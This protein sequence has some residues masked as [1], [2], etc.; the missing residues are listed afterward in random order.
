MWPQT[1]GW[2]GEGEGEGVGVEGGSGD[3]GGGGGGGEQ[4]CRQRLEAEVHLVWRILQWEKNL[5]SKKVTA[6]FCVLLHC[7]LE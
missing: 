6:A 2:R 1:R 7:R 3:V 4:G 5:S